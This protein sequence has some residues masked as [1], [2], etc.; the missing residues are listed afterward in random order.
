MDQIKDL[1]PVVAQTITLRAP[2]D[3]IQEAS[4]RAKALKDMVEK[5]HGSI[6]IAGQEHLRIEAWTTIAD[7]YGCK[8]QTIDAQP[9]EIFGVKGFKAMASVVHVQSGR[10]VTTAEAYCLQDEPN[11]MDK[12]WFQLASMAQTRAASKACSLAFRWVVVLSGFDAT[13]AEEMASIHKAPAPEPQTLDL[14]LMPFGKHK[15]KRL[16]DVPTDYLG[17]LLGDLKEKQKRPELQEALINELEARAMVPEHV[18]TKGDVNL[19]EYAKNAIL[20]EKNKGVAI[21][22]RAQYRTDQRLNVDQQVALD[23]VFNAKWAPPLD[24][25]EPEPES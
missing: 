22:T 4:E 16:A 13:P 19:F 17:W 8:V 20:N 15:G 2:N 18:T 24:V 11:W 9:I 23:D 10:V 12:A 14:G 6:Q 3:I 25:P 5:T 21:A 1:M 7:F